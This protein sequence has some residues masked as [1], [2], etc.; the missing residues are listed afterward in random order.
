MLTNEFKADLHIHSY[1]SDGTCSPEEILFLAK[2][3][4]ISVVSITDHDT[5][6]E[7]SSELFELSRKLNIRLIPGVEISSELFDAS[8]DILGYD[9]DL[10]SPSLKQFLKEVQDKR[11]LRNIEIL[12][13]LKENKVDISENELYEFAHRKKISNS[14]VGRAHM[15][16]LMVEKKYVKNIQD[17]FDNL[18]K[19][20]GPCYVSKFKFPS[21]TVID[22]IHKANGKA[23]I[24]HPCII[25]SSKVLKKLLTLP[26]DGLEAFYAR[27]TLS[28]VNIWLRIAENKNW[29]VSGGSDFHGDIK[30]YITLGCSWIDEQRFNKLISR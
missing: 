22:E 9:F 8:V 15:A 28:Q 20:E 21:Q 4:N 19:D 16:Q 7:Y 30:P 5:I 24:A 14:T 25:K 18:L 11:R 3:K 23:F 17:A 2:E 27:L 6:E 12:R 10:D 26:F 29:L 1:F 13:K